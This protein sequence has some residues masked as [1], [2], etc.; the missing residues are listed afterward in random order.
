MNVWVVRVTHACRKA[1]ANSSSGF[2]LLPSTLPDP[3][4]TSTAL[5]CTLSSSSS[6]NTGSRQA[7]KHR[8]TPSQSSPRSLE[9]KRCPPRRQEEPTC[10][11]LLTGPPAGPGSGSGSDTSIGEDEKSEVALLPVSPPPPPERCSEQRYL[12]HGRQKLS[13]LHTIGLNSYIM[14]SSIESPAA[15]LSGCGAERGAQRTL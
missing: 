13:E 3:V 14:W 8:Q 10:L 9:S 4:G 2:V 1:S 5:S 7:L 11:Q 12:S 6:A 15:P